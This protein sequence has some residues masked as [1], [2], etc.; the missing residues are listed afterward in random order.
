MINGNQELRDGD[1]NFEQV[2]AIGKG[3]LRLIPMLC[4][5]LYTRLT[6]HGTISVKNGRHSPA[7]K[8]PQIQYFKSIKLYY[9]SLFI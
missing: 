6:P 8:V 2:D 9:I 3:A 1:E 5:V 7:P 4:M